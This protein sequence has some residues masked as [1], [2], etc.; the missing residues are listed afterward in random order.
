M[1]IRL[2][3]DGANDWRMESGIGRWIMV[4][5]RPE[6]SCHRL[7]DCLWA[8]GHL[9]IWATGRLGDWALDD[10][11]PLSVISSA[12][13]NLH[14][15]PFRAS[16]ALLHPVMEDFTQ[17]IWRQSHPDLAS[18]GYMADPNES[19]YQPIA[20]SSTSIIPHPFNHSN[21]LSAGPSGTRS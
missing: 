10:I 2:A 4:T 11:E 7:E 5:M 6:G 15:F 8:S 3:S 13:K 14:I 21:S 12:F 18:Q 17:A 9:G 19:G 20:G 16:R 1:V